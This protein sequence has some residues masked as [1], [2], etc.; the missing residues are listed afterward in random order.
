MDFV[1]HKLKLILK[2]LDAIEKKLDEG[3]SE[4][5]DSYIS[6]SEAKKLL[7]RG[8]TLFWQL[9]KRGFP[10]SKLGGTVYYNINELLK[11]LEEGVKLEL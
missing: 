2:K 8:T 10:Y 3:K 9:K 1:K 5:G 11:L 4:N 7:G 6:E